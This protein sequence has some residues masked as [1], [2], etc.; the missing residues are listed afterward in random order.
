MY[1]CS[2]SNNVCI[3]SSSIRNPNAAVRTTY[4]LSVFCVR[5]LYPSY[6]KGVWGL[7]VFN[8]SINSVQL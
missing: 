4:C 7:G 6:G 2:I 1:E 3:Q 8:Q 5:G